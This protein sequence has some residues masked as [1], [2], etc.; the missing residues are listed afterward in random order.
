MGVCSIGPVTVPWRFPGVSS[1]FLQQRPFAAFCLPV[2]SFSSLHEHHG[3]RVQFLRRLCGNERAASIANSRH[4]QS[5]GQCLLFD[6]LQ[7]KT[8]FLT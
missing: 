5:D 3:E 2:L 1:D 8:L 7:L 4:V 6:A